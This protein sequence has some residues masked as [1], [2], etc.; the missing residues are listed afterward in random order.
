MMGGRRPHGPSQAGW[1]GGPLRRGESDGTGARTRRATG[2]AVFRRRAIQAGVTSLEEPSDLPYG[3]RR[4]M[5]R[6]EWS[7]VWQLASPLGNSGSMSAL[8]EP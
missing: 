5:V 7:N 1:R 6:D 3:D 8:E 4:G 2:E